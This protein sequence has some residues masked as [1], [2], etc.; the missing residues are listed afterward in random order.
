MKNKRIIKNINSK[1]INYIVSGIII[2]IFAFIISTKFVYIYETNDDHFLMSIINGTY[3]G[4][5]DA[6]AIYILYPFAFLIK[7]LYQMSSGINWYGY[8]IVGLHYMGLFLILGRALELSCSVL[9]KIFT[10][11][12]GMFL[13]ISIDLHSIVNTQYTI[14][15]G[16]LAAAALFFILTM[17]HKNPLKESILPGILLLITLNLRKDIFIVSMI[18][19]FVILVFNYTHEIQK[20]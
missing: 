20:K 15:A 17:K 3:T 2:I 9:K 19:I 5:P 14:T 8:S 6:H 10:I 11:I 1:F 12:I 13:I 4:S 18:F 7:K 16:V